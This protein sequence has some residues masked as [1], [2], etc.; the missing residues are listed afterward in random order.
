MPAI[1]AVPQSEKLLL[2]VEEAA[3]LLSL[4]RTSVF[5]LIKS[6]SLRS[7]QIGRSRR[8]PPEAVRAYATGL[9]AAQ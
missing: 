2:T 8:I 5:A 1:P 6:G 9:L 3:A 7:V 4:G